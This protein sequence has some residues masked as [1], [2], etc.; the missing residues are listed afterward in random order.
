MGLI[1]T[2]IWYIMSSGMRYVRV[3]NAAIDVQ[4]ACLTAI[5]RLTQELGETTPIGLSIG[6]SGSEVVFASPRD[7]SGRLRYDNQ[8]RLQWQKIVVFYVDTIEGVQCLMRKEDLL[9]RPLAKPPALPSA[10]TL[11]ADGALPPRVVA[12]HVK[13]FEAEYAVDEDTGIRSKNMVALKVVAEVETIE[14]RGATKDFKFDI[15]TS[16]VLGN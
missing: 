9:E 7:T 15:T 5:G 8:N 10:A 12:R 1:M 6:A 13:G 4:S 14:R 11:I 16:V 3:T 2:G